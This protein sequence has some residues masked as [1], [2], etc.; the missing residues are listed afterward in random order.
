VKYDRYHI[1]F[2]SKC[3]QQPEDN[4]PG[5]TLA[6]M[7]RKELLR[8]RILSSPIE[9]WRDSAWS[10]NCFPTEKRQDQVEM[11]LS[12]FEPDLWLLACSRLRPFLSFFFRHKENVTFRVLT[13]ALIQ[14]L[15]KEEFSDV[16]WH[17]KEPAFA[18]GATGVQVLNIK[19]LDSA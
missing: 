7:I 1:T 9:L 2:R 3:E 11:I 16:K 12:R 10:W 8:H 4:P 5:Q 6:E 19:T 15:S 14:V 17:L 18:K 13:E